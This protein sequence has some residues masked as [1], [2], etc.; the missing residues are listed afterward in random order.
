MFIHLLLKANHKKA[1]VNGKVV[2]RGQT[3]TSIPRLSDQLSMSFFKVRKA[4]ANLKKTGEISIKTTNNYSLVTISKYNKYQGFY[5][6]DTSGEKQPDDS[7]NTTNNKDNNDIE[8][9]INISQWQKNYLSNQR[10]IDSVS[11]ENKMDIEFIKKGLI[12]FVKT[13]KSVDNIEQSTIEFNRHFLNYLRK[14]KSS[15]V[16]SYS[17][18]KYDQTAY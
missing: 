12:S 7:Q 2:K 11:I 6:P 15:V 1:K 3:I 5:D 16:K 14:M 13:Q 10:L 8:D 18:G 9:N 4:L 17:R